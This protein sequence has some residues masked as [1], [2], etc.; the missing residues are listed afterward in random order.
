MV[1]ICDLLKGCARWTLF[2]FV[3]SAVF[4]TGVFGQEGLSTLRGTATDSS[5]AV[6]PGVELVAREVLTNITVRT[7][8]T[9]AQGNYEMPGLKAGKYQL[10]ATLSGFKKVVVDDIILQSSQVRRVEIVLQVGEVASEVTVSE[11]ATAIQTEQ[12]KIGAEFNAAKR[13][14]DLP[15]PGNAFSGT[16]AVL[17][18]LPDVQRRSG[19][20]SSGGAPTFAGQY[21]NQ[22][23]MSQ[24][25]VK[26]E[27]LNSQTVNMEAV[28]E[29]KA[30]A[31]NNTAEYARPGYFDTVTKSGTNQYH[32]EA[33]YYHR[34]SALGARSFFQSRKPQIIYHTFNLSGSGPIVKNKTFFYGLWNGERVPGSTFYLSTV[35]TEPMRNG[36]FSEF[37]QLARPVTIRDPLTGQAFTGNI[38]PAQ[39]LSSVARKVQ[40]S[41]LPPPNRPGLA[42][43][44][45]WLHPYPSDQFYADVFSVRIDHRL[46]EKNS[47]FGRIQTY[48]PK[49]VNAGT[50]PALAS[51]QLRPNYA[52]VFTDTHVFSPNLVNTFSTGGNRDALSYGKEVDGRKPGLASDIVKMLGL[53]GV[54]QQGLTPGGGSPVFSVT[55]YSTISVTAG[56]Y[57]L[58]DRN[59][60]F[61][62][63]VS[64]A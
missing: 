19:T 37:L 32:A 17:S 26:E 22:V 52:W 40:E 33:S 13:Y 64:W 27:T 6:V 39:R 29:L 54:N 15:I 11:L 12:G 34:N 56:G 20:G 41:F 62:D 49:Y 42:N 53:Q 4:P 36:D 7:G 57:Y 21:G 63:N 30:V 5:G 31:V 47:L 25:G 9:D 59:F 61:A 46:S 38:I 55:G 60:N 23:H 3:L 24:D 35:P 44:L 58:A 10:T 45:G 48:F 28:A 14:Q 16:Y 50:Y 1:L 51:T 18:L 43:N 2:L 8:K